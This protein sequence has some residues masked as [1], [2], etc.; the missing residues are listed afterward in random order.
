MVSAD[1]CGV[2]A[3]PRRPTPTTR[4]VAPREHGA[5]GILL[6]P[7]ATAVGVAGRAPWPVWLFFL[8]AV[9]A[10]VARAN[11]VRQRRGWAWA[12]LAVA[13]ACG[14]VLVAVW[15]RWWLVPV[16]LG[17][18]PL[19]WQ[20]TRHDLRWQLAAG[21][22]L[23][24]TAPVGWYVIHGRWE[25]MAGWLWVLNAAFFV[26][27]MLHVRMHRTA[28]VARR[29]CRR[30]QATGNVV[31]HAALA[32]G[33]V[34]AWPAAAGWLL[35]AARAAWGAWRLRP[36]VNIRRLGWIEVGHSLGFGLLVVYGNG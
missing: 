23:T 16:G 12:M 35:A 18:T 8:A 9:S 10:H 1:S 20:K 7:L 17:L 29:V 33:A 6:I 2:A 22:G 36:Q 11:W 5:W 25:V 27:G 3:A 34:V 30:E 15:Q 19:W 14:A 31:Y 24:T 28:A 13:G 4:P 26:G 32:V 21:L